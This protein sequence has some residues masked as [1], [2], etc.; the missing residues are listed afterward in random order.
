MSQA[1][2]QGKLIYWTKCDDTVDNIAWKIYGQTEN[3]TEKIFEE[4]HGLVNFGVYL[5]ENLPVI[6]PDIENIEKA[7]GQVVL[8]Q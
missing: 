4:N 2:Q 8:W 3:V 1:K 7:S 6:I 5:P